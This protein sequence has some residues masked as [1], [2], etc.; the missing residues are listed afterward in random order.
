MDSYS[1]PSFF[2]RS[3]DE[4]DEPFILSLSGRLWITKPGV[5]PASMDP[6][7][8]TLS[9]YA[10]FSCALDLSLSSG[11]SG[12]HGFECACLLGCARS[13]VGITQPDIEGLLG[14]AQARCDFVDRMTAIDDL[15]DASVPELL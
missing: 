9:S 7:G 13:S 15:P 10:G 11:I 1:W 4:A 8:P 14:Y 6:K 3:L 2:R 5:E 12:F